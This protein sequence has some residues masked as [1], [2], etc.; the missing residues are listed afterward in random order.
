MGDTEKEAIIHFLY[1]VCVFLLETDRKTASFV[2]DHRAVFLMV[3]Y[4][5]YFTSD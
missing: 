5:L 4:F 1:C 3:M 2:A